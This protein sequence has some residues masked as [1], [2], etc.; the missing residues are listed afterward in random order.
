MAEMQR[1]VGSN[2]AATVAAATPEKSGATVTVCCK[3]PNGVVIQASEEYTTQEPV[4]GGGTRQVK[5]YKRVGPQ[6]K[7]NGFAR[8]V[9]VDAAHPI[10]GGYGLTH[11]VSKALWE[12]WLPANR[13]SDLVQNNLIFAHEKQDSAAGQAA[14]QKDLK[15][16]W[17]ALNT[18]RKIV[19]GKSVPVDPRFPTSIEK[20]DLK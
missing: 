19:N 10:I 5:A 4:M 9:G 12:N 1:S 3:T 20:S 2:A 7:L 8:A 18:E 16:G 15:S 17:D 11:G 14:D 13:D 6:V